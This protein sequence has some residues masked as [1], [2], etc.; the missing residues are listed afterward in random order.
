ME[1]QRDNTLTE[2]DGDDNIWIYSGRADPEHT[3]RVALDQASTRSTS[4]SICS[5]ATSL[6]L[7]FEYYPV[8]K[9]SGIWI[10]CCCQNYYK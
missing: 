7:I 10:D 2:F 1:M 5:S 9:I 6:V 4:A 8:D 3:M